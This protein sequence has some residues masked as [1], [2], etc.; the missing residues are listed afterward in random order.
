MLWTTNFKAC[1]DALP[2]A[3]EEYLQAES[4]DCS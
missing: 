1:S 3:A 2:Y 4:A